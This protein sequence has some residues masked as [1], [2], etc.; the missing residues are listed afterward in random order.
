MR[1]PFCSV[2]IRLDVRHRAAYPSGRMDEQ[3]TGFEL[4]QGFCPECAQFVVMTK[5]GQFRFIEGEGEVTEIRSEELIYPKFL[6]RSM[7]VEIPSEYKDDFNEANAV[8]FVSP[9]ASAALSRRLLQRLLHE[10]FSIRAR[11]LSRE[12]D[13]FLKIPNIPSSIRSAVDAIRQ[14]GNFGAHPLKYRNT[15]E[16]V[17]VETGEAELSLDVLEALLDFHFVQPRR[18]EASAMKLNSKL[19]AL[20]KPPLK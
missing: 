11:D 14:V 8:L 10:A 15:A 20:G 1:C 16:I 7:A 12:I 9:K 13:E 4:V 5:W 18:N 6:Q 17:D 2:G 19:Q 3:G